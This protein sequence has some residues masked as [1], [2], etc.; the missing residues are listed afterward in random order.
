MSRVVH[1]RLDP[2]TERLL[3]RLK[4]QRGWSD[5]EIVRLGIRSLAQLE[6]RQRQGRQIVGLGRFRSKVRDLGSNKKHLDGF[7]R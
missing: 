3:N 2:A 7:G 1:A 4:R 6:L 5:S